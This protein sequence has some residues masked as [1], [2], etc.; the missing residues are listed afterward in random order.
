MAVGKENL[1]TARD[2]MLPL[3]MSLYYGGLGAIRNPAAADH[4]QL[5]TTLPYGLTSYLPHLSQSL[6]IG[7]RNGPTHLAHTNILLATGKYYTHVGE[8][9]RSPIWHCILGTSPC[10]VA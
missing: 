10:C 4:D 9:A 6:H 3:F 7:S 2:K 8:R 5:P 1:S